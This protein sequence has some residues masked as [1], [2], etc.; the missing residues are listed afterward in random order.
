MSL[1]PANRKAWAWTAGALAVG[2]A[3]GHLLGR[4]EPAEQ[5]AA[6]AL[7]QA[8]LEALRAQSRAASGA[9]ERLVALRQE[10]VAAEAAL[11]AALAARTPAEGAAEAASGA[12]PD[13][14][15]TF[16]DMVLRIG[17]A[18]L[19]GR[20]DGRLGVLKERLGLTPAQ[21]AAVK[22]ILDE[23]SAAAGAALDRLMAG[24]GTPSDFG[25]L[26]RL[27]RG[28]LPRGV[29]GALT[30]AQKPVYAAFQEQERVSGV[31]NRVNMELSGLVGAGGLTPEQKDQ[32]FTGLSGLLMAED[33]TDFEA[34]KDGRE[35]RGYMDE[36]TARRY[37]LMDPILTEP[38]RQVYRQQVD[39][40]REMLNKL[41]PAETP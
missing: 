15:T 34:M 20:I 24:E 9:Q 13:P 35:V 12:R 38:Q 31:E 28:E 8:E 19:T 36:A 1:L 27:Q 16:A 3:G 26:A 32:A 2:L 6:M 29:E 33:A 11:A 37:E 10:L 17:Q 4:R 25:R 41:L 14:K 40:G 39:M 21:E 22:Q 5:R 23:E 30:D 18:Q 7:M